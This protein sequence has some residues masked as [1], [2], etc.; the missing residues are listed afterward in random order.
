MEEKKK[1]IILKNESA[2]NSGY[3]NLDELM[4]KFNSFLEK[5]SHKAPK[6]LY[7]IY[8]IEDVYQECCV[9]FIKAFHNYD[10]SKNVGF[11]Q[12][13][14]I[15]VEDYLKTLYI[16]TYKCRRKNYDSFKKVTSYDKEMETGNN[17][18]VTNLLET[19]PDE[20]GDMESNIITLMTVKDT[21]NFDLTKTE[22]DIFIDVVI[23]K[24]SQNVVGARYDVSQPCISKIVKTCKD[25]IIKKLMED[26]TINSGAN[27]LAS[28]VIKL[29]KKVNVDELV[30]ICMKYGTNRKSFG[31]IAEYLNIS[32]KS[33]GE[34]L[35]RYHVKE[36]INKNK[37]KKDA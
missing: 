32:P 4:L 29:K 9:A 8:D 22:K 33:V 30:E 20:S 28:N 12:Y 10:S 23:N 24:T 1:Y 34:Y 35:Y 13:L 11:Q 27:S 18:D 7:N 19:I 26:D 16:E 31:K 2:D 21:I 17:Y 5:Y 15:F 6:Y 3:Y 25:K 14:K 37:L 36:I